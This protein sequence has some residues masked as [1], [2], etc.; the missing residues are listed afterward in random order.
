[1]EG[2]PEQSALAAV[3]DVRGDIEEDAP[4]A[5]A[6]EPDD[7]PS[8]LDDVEPSGLARCM[9]QEHR[10]IEAAEDDGAAERALGRRLSLR[11]RAAA[12][13]RREHAEDRQEDQDAHRVK[14][15]DCAAAHGA[16]E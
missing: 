8:L 14:G 13:E 5:G 12:G 9:G 10:R 4:L 2:E 7:S 16:P 15:S 3:V 11:R 1:M 6:V